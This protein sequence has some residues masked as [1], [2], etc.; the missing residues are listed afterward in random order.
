V[1]CPFGHQPC[2][3]IA[4]SDTQRTQQGHQCDTP[5]K[6]AN[7]SFP[8]RY[9]L[10]KLQRGPR[11]TIETDSGRRKHVQSI[12]KPTL[13]RRVGITMRSSLKPRTPKRESG[14]GKLPGAN[15]RA[16][17]TSVQKEQLRPTSIE[18]RARGPTTKMQNQINKKFSFQT[19]FAQ[20][21]F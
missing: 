17:T 19:R 9:P 6:A 16:Q 7:D 1:A 15:K 5:A 14:S 18:R 12:N 3:I 2:K 20:T 13:Q 11:Q 10:R 21:T 4:Q 8:W